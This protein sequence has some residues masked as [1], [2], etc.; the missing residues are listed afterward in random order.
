MKRDRFGEYIDI[1][2]FSDLFPFSLWANC[3]FPLLR[4]FCSILGSSKDDVLILEEH[5]E[6]VY[7]NIRN[8]KDFQFVTV[9]IFSNTFSKVLLNSAFTILISF[10]FFL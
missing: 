8:T 5:N 6:N 7:L 2:E 1:L 4:I 9:N 3:I 10:F